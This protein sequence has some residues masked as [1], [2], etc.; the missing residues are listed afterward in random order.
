[1]Q[2]D[3]SVILWRELWGF[4][5]NVLTQNY[6][7]LHMPPSFDEYKFP[8]HLKEQSVTMFLEEIEKFN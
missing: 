4:L 5:G 7:E 1:M 2:L 6:I 8:P 3:N